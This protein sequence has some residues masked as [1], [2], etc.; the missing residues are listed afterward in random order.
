MN[1]L[2]ELIWYLCASRPQGYLR[3]ELVKY[4]YLCDVEFYRRFNRLITG[5]RYEF[6]D[7]GPFNWDILDEATAM[8]E[9]DLL[10]VRRVPAIGRGCYG[11]VF[12]TRGDR[13]EEVE[14]T[15]L[16]NRTLSVIQ[17]VLERFSSLS[18]DTLLDHVYTTPPTSL[19]SKGESIDFREWIPSAD[20]D[21]VTKERVKNRMAELRQSAR[22]RMRD[23]YPEYDVA[24]KQEEADHAEVVSALM[25]HIIDLVQREESPPANRRPKAETR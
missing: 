3:T 4:V 20:L 24:A 1:V 25:P 15:H 14:L 2:S 7:Y 9:D 11:N 19:F 10:S 6:V 17:D 13:S 21:Y 12:S 23:E 16:D 18:L 22:A 8:V 5:L